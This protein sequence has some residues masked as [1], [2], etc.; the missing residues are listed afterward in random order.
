MLWLKDNWPEKGLLGLIG[1]EFNK[2]ARLLNGIEGF[3]GIQVF[4]TPAGL[5]FYGSQGLDLSLFAFGWL[6]VDGQQAI[7]RGGYF[8]TFGQYTAVGGAENYVSI[9]GSIDNRHLI[10]AEISK[11]SGPRILPNSILAS[12]FTGDTADTIRQPLYAVYLDD[13]GAVVL[14]AVLHLGVMTP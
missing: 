9:G 11:Q 6:G 14:D 4:R 5:Q 8:K 3:G 1:R 13:D 2:I 10:I 7:I 12:S